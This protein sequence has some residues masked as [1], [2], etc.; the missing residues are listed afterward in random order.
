MFFGASGNLSTSST[1]V[2]AISIQAS[3]EPIPNT[4]IDAEHD[5]RPASG[6]SVEGRLMRAAAYDKM[7]SERNGS[8]M[9]HYFQID[10]FYKS[11]QVFSVDSDITNPGSKSFPKL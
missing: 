3:F 2:G 1:T 10:D 7:T 11:T 6:P 5:I 4:V 9:L 8:L